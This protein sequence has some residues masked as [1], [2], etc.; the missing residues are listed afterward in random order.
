[1]I[2]TLLTALSLA[3]TPAVALPLDVRLVTD[4]SDAVLAVLAKRSAG[5]TVA[6]EDWARLFASE[7]Y[8]RLKARETAMQRPFEDED[9]KRF[10]SGDE[11]LARRETLAGTLASWRTVDPTAAARR[12]MAYLPS[13]TALRAKIYPVIK[14]RDNSFVFDLTGDPAIFLYLDPAQTKEQFENTLAHELHH[15]GFAAGCAGKK[16]TGLPERAEA[17]VGWLSAFGE[18]VA[19]LAAAGGP[20]VHPHAVSKPAD[21]ERWDRDLAGFNQDLAKVEAFLQGILAGTLADDQISEQGFSFFG[22]QGPWYTVGWKMAAMV[23]QSEGRD[24]LVASLCD[25]RELLR[26]YDRAAAKHNETAKDKLAR[27]SPALLQAL[28]ASPAPAEGP[29]NRILTP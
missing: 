4:E 25:P 12:A 3:A 21:R 8:L 9:F 23:E 15:I 18:G 22:V 2:P 10:V 7:G 11:L 5:E 1:M 28:A 20:E 13:G 16:P 6:A 17:A 29:A 27:W 24:R 26:A 19:M 14:P